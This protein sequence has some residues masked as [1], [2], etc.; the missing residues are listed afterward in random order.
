MPGYR[1]PTATPMQTSPPAPS[2]ET[3]RLLT[4][5]DL[6]GAVAGMRGARRRRGTRLELVCWELNIDESLAHPAWEAALR[7]RLLEATE[8]DPL[9]GKPMYVLSDR[10]HRAVYALSPRRRRPD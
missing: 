8:D 4:L 9:T 3:K 1:T 10:G 7:G 5:P 2:R 6:L